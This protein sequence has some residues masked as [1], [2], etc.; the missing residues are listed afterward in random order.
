MPDTVEEMRPEKAY[1]HLLINPWLKGGQSD[2][3]KFFSQQWHAHESAV[4]TITE[5]EEVIGCIEDL[6]S[7]GSALPPSYPAQRQPNATIDAVVVSHEFTDYMHKE[8]LLEVPLSVPV[9]AASKAAGIIRSWKHFKVVA[10]MPTNLTGKNRDW[11]VA[12]IEPLPS[13][14]GISRL[15]QDK[16]DLL[17]YHSAVMFAF[18]GSGKDRNTDIEKAEAVIYTPRGITPEDLKPI[19]TAEPPIQTLAQMHGLHDVRIGPQLN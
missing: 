11:R 10:T 6:A 3:V 16:I 18:G 8:T 12:S 2:V 7:S 4:Q 13:W 19:A 15:G 17:Y 5:V 14:L 9:F 1:F